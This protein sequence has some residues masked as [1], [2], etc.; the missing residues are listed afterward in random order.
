MATYQERKAAAR[1]T[2]IQWQY[3]NMDYQY[4]YEGLIILQEYFYKLGKRYGL[5]TEF[6]E[7]GIP[8]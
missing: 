3:E 7:N 4:S 1:E 8:C 2:A 6:R 5:L